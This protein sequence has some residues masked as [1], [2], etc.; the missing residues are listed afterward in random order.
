MHEDQKNI[1]TYIGTPARN[2]RTVLEQVLELVPEQFMNIKW[3][4]KN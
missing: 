2:S 3:Q 4:F 1:K